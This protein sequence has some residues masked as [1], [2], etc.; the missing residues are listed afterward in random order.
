MKQLVSAGIFTFFNNSQHFFSLILEYLLYC[1]QEKL[2]FEQGGYLKELDRKSAVFILL[3][4]NLLGWSI[5]YFQMENCDVHARDG[6]GDLDSGAFF[7]I[8]T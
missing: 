6:K 5:G 3:S 8:Q 7:C 2:A 4:I 1:T